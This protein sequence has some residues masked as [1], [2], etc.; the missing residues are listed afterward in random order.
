MTADQ[1]KSFISWMGTKRMVI[2]GPVH[3]VFLGTSVLKKLD[4]RDVSKVIDDYLRSQHGKDQ[5]C[6]VQDPISPT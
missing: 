4:D 5:A 3:D 2:A 6:A 1:L